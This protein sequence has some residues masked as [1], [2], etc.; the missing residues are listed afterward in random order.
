MAVPALAPSSNVSISGL[1]DGGI[2]PS[3][4]GTA[5]AGPLQRSNL[6]IAGVEDLGAGLKAMFRLS[7]RFDIDTG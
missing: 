6:A 4:D 5:Q 2:S 1:I 3:V 7:T